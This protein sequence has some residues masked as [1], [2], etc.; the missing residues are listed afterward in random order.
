[1]VKELKAKKEAQRP[2]IVQESVNSPFC[3]QVTSVGAASVHVKSGGA[4]ALVTMLRYST[5]PLTAI[6]VGEIG[7][8]ATDEVQGTNAF[9]DQ[10]IKLF[11]SHYALV[12]NSTSATRSHPRPAM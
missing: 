8:T 2:P 10:G 7:H 3:Q 9:K 5:L 4:K 1:L 12:W 11:T 6:K